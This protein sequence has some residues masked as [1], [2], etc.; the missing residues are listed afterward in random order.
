MIDEISFTIN[1][2][3]S[4]WKRTGIE[5]CAWIAFVQATQVQTF[6]ILDDSLYHGQRLRSPLRFENSHVSILDAGNHVFRP[7]LKLSPI[8]TIL[9]RWLAGTERRKIIRSAISE[10]NFTLLKRLHTL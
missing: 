3:F 7:A 9:Y 8:G 6:P 5:I 10:K 4:G 1:D 2:E